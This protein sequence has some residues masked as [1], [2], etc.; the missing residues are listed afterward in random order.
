MVKEPQDYKKKETKK[1]EEAV[2]EIAIPGTGDIIEIDGGEFEVRKSI[3]SVRSLRILSEINK[4]S[5]L[6]RAGEAT[7]EEAGRLNFVV[8]DLLDHCFGKRQVEK[9]LDFIEEKELD[10]KGEQE[11]LV[12]FTDTLAGRNQEKDGNEQ[13]DDSPK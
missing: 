12:K 2:D 8:Y 5:S 7:R 3:N 10:D 4:L 1:K 9:I 13:E 6:V 11:L